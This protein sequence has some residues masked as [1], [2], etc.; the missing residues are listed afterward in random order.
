MATTEEIITKLDTL[1]TQIEELEDSVFK[2][3]EVSTY[4]KNKL[5]TRVENVK[6]L[7][8][9]GSP[10][11]KN[12]AVF[13]LT[14]RIGRPLDSGK[15]FSWV[16]VPLPDILRLID[17][18][19]DDIESTF[20]NTPP[21]ALIKID[22]SD[23]GQYFTAPVNVEMNFDGTASW[24]EDGEIVGWEWDFGDATPIINESATRHT[25]T[26]MGT[27]RVVLTVT[28]NGSPAESGTDWVEITVV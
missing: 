25:F 27:Y 22:G 4:L 19:I 16:K 9:N 8:N 6:A 20:E 14:W 21:N 3:P 10:N 5:K 13:V 2:V 18:I 11:A 17:E 1:K 26:M 15:R 28:D 12:A 7:V 23:V 24:D